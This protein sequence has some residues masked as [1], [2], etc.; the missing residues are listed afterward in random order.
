MD[1]YQIL[2]IASDADSKEIRRAYARLIKEFR[3]ETHPVEFANI[4]EAYEIALANY[5]HGLMQAAEEEQSAAAA[6]SS[7]AHAQVHP[8][9]DAEPSL[10]PAQLAEPAQAHTAAVPADADASTDANTEAEQPLHP[11]FQYLQ[12]LEDSGIAR[13]EL[14]GEALTLSFLPSLQSYTLDEYAA[15]EYE[16]LNWVFNTRHTLLLAYLHMDAVF[17]WTEHQ[18]FSR[19][20][21]NHGE[22]DWLSKLKLAAQT[23]QRALQQQDSNL[24]GG[25]KSLMRWILS[26]DDIQLRKQWQ[27]W[28]AE[29]ELPL[30]QPY[31]KSVSTSAFPLKRQHLLY[32]TLSAAFSGWLADGDMVTTL[33]VAAV[34]FAAMLAVFVWLVPL[35]R[36]YVQRGE[37]GS[38]K[39]F[40][41]FLVLYALFGLG[42]AIFEHSSDVM[43]EKLEREVAREQAAQA[44]DPLQM[45]VGP[46]I[47]TGTTKR[48]PPEY[49]WASRL[50]RESGVVETLLL[51]D[52]DG[53]V[54]DVQVSKSS[55]HPQLDQAAVDAARRW[56]FTPV[57]K[58]GQARK[59]TVTA[60]FRFTL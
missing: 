49:P 38:R 46:T 28:C 39:Y 34:T 40:V 31:F 23:Y 24:A 12:Q 26:E 35:C 48:S 27:Q 20:A 4:R 45:M 42:R 37:T 21:F 6:E 15:I 9:V 41:Y 13:D 3:P 2:G 53:S 22:V 56:C 51:V 7:P 8:A 17:K 14:R 18:G 19:R 58:E 25:K 43:P 5:N 1:I 32:A 52:L 10:A 29:L 30:L 44:M 16:V 60:P 33:A 36:I 47:C 59:F 54:L 57:M 50:N 11:V 55:G